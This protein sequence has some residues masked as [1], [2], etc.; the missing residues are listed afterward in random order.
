[1]KKVVFVAL[2]AVM[3]AGCAWALTDEEYSLYM[4]DPAFSAADRKF[5]ATWETV[6]Q[7]LPEKEGN[8]I[9]K[10]LYFWVRERAESQAIHLAKE[11][12]ITLAA[13]YAETLNKQVHL[14]ESVLN[15]KAKLVTISGV[16]NSGMN[17]PN[18]PYFIN[19]VDGTEAGEYR[20]YG[21]APVRETV[22]RTCRTM[23]ICK[24]TGILGEATYVGE[25]FA[26]V[27]DVELIEKFD[28]TKD[29]SEE[30]L[31]KN[32]LSRLKQMSQDLLR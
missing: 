16:I 19:T 18:S 3:W 27:T 24:I 12:K 30:S 29:D 26:L 10:C 4:K 1:M 13:A 8:F 22:T 17:L 6:E 21:F 11:K 32:R 23:D 7:A 2:L 20:Q 25:T 15:K 14:V 9:H 5:K 28:L 31:L